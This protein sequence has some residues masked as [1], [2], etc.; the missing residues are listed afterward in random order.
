MIGLPSGNGSEDELTWFHYDIF[1][2]TVGPYVLLF[3]DT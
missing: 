2:Q 3:G 1:K